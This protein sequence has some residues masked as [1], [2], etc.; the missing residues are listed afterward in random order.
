MT[1]RVYFADSVSDLE[2]SARK[3]TADAAC[4]CRPAPEMVA[5]LLL[6]TRVAARPCWRP[7][8]EF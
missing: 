7:P 2:A 3:W 5:L 6:E 1:D 4:L 8:S